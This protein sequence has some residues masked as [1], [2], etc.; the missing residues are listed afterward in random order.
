MNFERGDTAIVRNALK[1]CMYRDGQFKF[2]ISPPLAVRPS[3]FFNF[4]FQFAFQQLERP[5]VY[6]CICK[7]L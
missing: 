6:H 2:T 1:I 7:S 3:H 4:Q 5:S